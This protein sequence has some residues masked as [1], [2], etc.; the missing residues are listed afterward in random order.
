[1][2]NTLEKTND[3]FVLQITDNRETEEIHSFRSCYDSLETA[4]VQ[5][6]IDIIRVIMDEGTT[7][8]KDI[9][10]HRDVLVY[11]AGKVKWEIVRA[12]M[13]TTKHCFTAKAV[14]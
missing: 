1:M 10:W 5:M 3:V 8:F 4:K 14:S 12:S 2:D 13:Y 6:Y 9:Q 7:P 11:E